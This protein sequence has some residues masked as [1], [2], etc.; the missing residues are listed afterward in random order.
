VTAT[1]QE[2]A[3]LLVDA[4]GRATG[5]VEFGDGGPR[6]FVA[7]APDEPAPGDA[8]RVE[9]DALLADPPGEL[10]RICAFAGI[11]YDQAL[12]T[13]IEEARRATKAAAAEWLASVS[14]ASFGQ[15][16]AAAGS[17]LLVSTYQTNKLVCARM[18]ADAGGLN[19]HFRDMD[20][21]MGLAVA[22]GRIALGTRTEVWDLRDMPEAAAKLEPAGSHDACY[23]PRNRH[24]TGDIAVHELAFAGGELW[25]V[26]TA[27]SC[28]ATLDADHSFVPR[29]RPPFI[30]AL[31]AEDRCHLNG[32]AVVDGR[33][34][35]VTALGRS[36]E[37]GGWRENKAAGGLLLDVATSE[38]V[39][40]GLSMPHS[41]R[42][43]GGRLWLLESGRGSLATVDL[44][45]GAVQTVAELPGFTRGLAF[46]GDLAFIGLSQIRESSTFGD[47]PVT[48]RL[49][50][51][52]CGVW[53]VDLR[54]GEIAGFLRFEDLVQEIFDVGLLAGVRFPEIAE[55]TSPIVASSF[56]LP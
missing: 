6:I 30:T 38:V 1:R 18:P 20:K 7:S 12:L 27:F 25:L 55:A 5:G 51:R 53:M 16:L 8:L 24:V 56:A 4:L 35:F 23:L 13:P 19:T 42:W 34:A 40:Q 17:S 32:M 22:P 47:L 41:P 29:W 10:R 28:L 11:T 3:A 48:H 31:T 26:A 21:P 14:T 54:S 15:A 36:D 50:E 2:D 9:R 43:H 46:L 39:A 45:T 44:A 52:Q 37:P 49:S 33:V